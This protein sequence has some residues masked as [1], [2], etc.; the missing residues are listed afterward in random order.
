MNTKKNP[1]LPTNKNSILSNIVIFSKKAKTHIFG[2]E[3][4][5]RPNIALTRGF[6]NRLKN[7]LKK[8][9]YLRTSQRLV[10]FLG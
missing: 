7:D 6:K 5:T 10:Q 8:K 3:R 4:F 9:K 2:N 1:I